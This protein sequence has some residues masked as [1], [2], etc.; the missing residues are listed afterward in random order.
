MPLMA[1]ST[2]PSCNLL[3]HARL[4]ARLS[5]LASLRSRLQSR[6]LRVDPKPLSLA[7]HWDTIP[8]TESQLE[9][10][11]YFIKTHPP[12]KLWTADQW[13]KRNEAEDSSSHG[14]KDQLTPE[15]AFLGR[16]NV[17]KS[18]LLNALLQ[19]PELN[20]VGPRPGKTTTMHAWGLSAS[21]PKTGGAGPGGEMKVRLA[22]LDMPGYGFAS[23]DEWVEENVTYL[24]RRKQ[25]RR[26]FLLIDA[27]HGIKLADEQMVELLRNEGISYQVVVSK[28]DRLLESGGNKR[29]QAFFELLRREIVQPDTGKGMD[30]LGEIL[31]VGHLGDKKRSVKITEQDMLGIDRVRWAVLVAAGLEEWA[32]KRA[33]KKMRTDI[34]ESKPFMPDDEVMVPEKSRDRHLDDGEQASSA[35][36]QPHD[37]SPP[38]S[39]TPTNEEKT[40]AERTPSFASSKSSSTS[41]PTAEYH[42]VSALARLDSRPLTKKAKQHPERMPVPARLASLQ[43]GGLAELEAQL[44]SKST[45]YNHKGRPSSLHSSKHD[46]KAAA[47]SKTRTSVQMSNN[48]E[49]R[50]TST[51]ERIATPASGRAAKT[52]S[53]DYRE[54]DRNSPETARRSSYTSSPPPPPP[55]SA[56]SYASPPPPRMINGK[57]VGGM[58]DLLATSNSS[59]RGHNRSG[60]GGRADE[61]AGGRKRKG[62]KEKVIRTRRGKANG[63]FKAAAK[64]KALAR[65]GNV[66]W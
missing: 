6:S 47:P 33:N 32:T 42:R 17:G 7:Y 23:R 52:T 65:P 31:A 43:V 24:R 18:S 5:F 46:R 34:I 20:R 26:A 59:S 28:A 60:S 38:P 11:T 36:T 15:V 2:C 16:S 51:R 45:T 66:G 3:L 9:A 30:G 35:P 13:R 25:L 27:L 37:S 12:R 58:A 22:V 57:G 54:R 8:P 40:G 56:T 10:A 49:R 4:R 63:R 21:N 14:L 62:K 29:L 19:A 48:L 1:P 41:Y 55:R 44:P 39:G 64:A 53:D 61:V 50:P